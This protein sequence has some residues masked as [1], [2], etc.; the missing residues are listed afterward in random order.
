LSFLAIIILTPKITT[1]PLSLTL[2]Y[3]IGLLTVF[4]ALRVFGNAVFRLEE[5]MQFEAGTNI[6]T[7]II[8]LIGGLYA[9]TF[10]PSPENLALAYMTGSAIGLATIVYLIN[11]YIR[12][13]FRFFRKDLVKKI[14]VAGWPIGFSAIFGGLLV[15]MDTVMIGWFLNAESVGYYSAAQK[16]IAFLYLLPA[17]IIGALLPVMSRYAKSSVDKFR[18]LMERGLTITLLLAL[19]LV[20]GLVLNSR[21]IIEIV[22]GMEFIDAALPMSVLAITILATFP[23]SI[24]THAI[25]A[26]DRQKEM[27]FMWIVGFIINTVLNLVLIPTIGLLG[28]AI[29][30]VVSQFLI[31]GVFY[32]KMQ[33]INSFR[34][35]RDTASIM[36]ASLILILVNLIMIL[37]NAPFLLILLTSVTIYF[38]ALV[39]LN[40]PTLKGL[41]AVV[42][43]RDDT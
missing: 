9:L 15:N 21:R 16:P 19:P 8:I 5:R 17:F 18:Q 36:N 40:D 4:D 12:D 11:K 22:Y 33:K 14:L 37:V 20:A 3:A 26:F 10:H 24:I 29:A 13:A 42:R 1:L 43:G 38:G 31:I 23:G 7:Q 32:V 25:F 34:L 6:L 35:F 28:A 27:V 39:A 41:L 2:I 30:S